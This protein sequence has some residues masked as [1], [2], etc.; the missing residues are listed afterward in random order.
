MEYSFQAAQEAEA[1]TLTTEE[2][3][4]DLSTGGSGM[5][6]SGQIP[7]EKVEGGETPISQSSL[8]TLNVPGQDGNL[9]VGKSILSVP[10]LY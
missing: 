5:N 1:V 9:K 4:S 7:E 3:L 2:T 6:D 10:F 8:L